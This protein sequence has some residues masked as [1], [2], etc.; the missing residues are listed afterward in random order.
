MDIS[1]ID[2]LEDILDFIEKEPKNFLDVL[3]FFEN[4]F[5]DILLQRLTSKIIQRSLNIENQVIEYHAE[6]LYIE[7]NF[8][9]LQANLI[10]LFDCILNDLNK[11]GYD[12]DHLSRSYRDRVNRTISDFCFC[13][14]K[15][16]LRKYFSKI[17]TF[18]LKEG[19]KSKGINLIREGLDHFFDYLKIR[20]K[21]TLLFETDIEGMLE[22]ILKNMEL[23]EKKA[24]QLLSDIENTF[25]SVENQGLSKMGFLS[26]FVSKGEQKIFIK[27]MDGIVSV[28]LNPVFAENN[29]LDGLILIKQEISKMNPKIKQNLKNSILGKDKK[30][31]ADSMSMEGLFYRVVRYAN[32]V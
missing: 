28:V 10:T 3:N 22:D 2:N 4:N 27:E 16:E 11:E 15:E 25:V 8:L 20:R 30:L 7:D 13:L 12:L 14:K 24:K 5:N 6:T 1:Q 23:L 32:Q 29:M 9:S 18:F 19:I 31:L 26:E 17:Y 21:I